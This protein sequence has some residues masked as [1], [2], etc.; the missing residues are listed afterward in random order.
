[1]SAASSPRM[2]PTCYSLLGRCCPRFLCRNWRLPA[3]SYSG[4]SCPTGSGSARRR[5]CGVRMY[6]RGAARVGRV[7]RR[8]SFFL[9]PQWSCLGLGGARCRSLCCHGRLHLAILLASRRSR[10]IAGARSKRRPRRLYLGCGLIWRASGDCFGR[11]ERGGGG[12]TLT[13]GSQR[14]RALWKWREMC[15][16]GFASLRHRFW[17]RR[18]CVYMTRWRCFARMCSTATTQAGWRQL[19]L[20]EAGKFSL[21][22]RRV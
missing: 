7:N 14:T 2:Q 4:W 21:W 13:S 10:G 20:S 15:H 3:H 6:Q 12:P 18:K 17:R 5:Y 9:A 16:D 8:V 11:W 19:F 22:H 1:L